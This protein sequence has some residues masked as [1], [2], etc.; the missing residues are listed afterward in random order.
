V[1]DNGLPIAPRAPRTAGW[2]V[3]GVG[4]V[5]IGAGITLLVLAASLNSQSASE[6]IAS[7]GSG[8]ADYEAALR[9]QAL[10]YAIGGVGLAAV[11]VGV[12]L[13]LSSAPARRSSTRRLIPIVGPHIAGLAWRAPF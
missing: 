13:V 6:N 12:Y 4:V 7:R 11:G 10:G 5:G 9:D 1:V 3:A 2:I 8:H